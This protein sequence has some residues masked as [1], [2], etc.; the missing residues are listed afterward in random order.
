MGNAG[1][2]YFGMKEAAMTIEQSITGMVKVIDDSTR[3]KTSGRFMTWEGE[4][5]PW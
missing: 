2:K 1:A 5:Y 4:E 3:E